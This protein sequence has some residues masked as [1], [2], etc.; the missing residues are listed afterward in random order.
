MNKL[1]VPSHLIDKA[2]HGLVPFVGGIVEILNEFTN[3]HELPPKLKG[4]IERFEVREWAQVY[5][6][7]EML[8]GLH[9]T[10]FSIAN[11]LSPTEIVL[12]DRVSSD[13]ALQAWN[14]RAWLAF[15]QSW[16]AD[17]D[18]GIGIDALLDG[19]PLPLRAGPEG[20]ASGSVQGLLL[21]IAL[22]MCHNSFACM[23]H[24]QSLFQLV[25]AAKAGDDDALLKA[26]QIDK[27]CLT[28]IPYFQARL[29]RA[30]VAGD[31]RFVQRV[32]QYR[33]KPAFQS[34]TQLQP[35]F[36]VFSFLDT[37]GLLDDYALDLE[38]FADLCQ[39]LGVYGPADDAADLDSFA[40][41]LRR[42][43]AQYHTQRPHSK[44]PLRVKDTR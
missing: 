42:F 34:A 12:P 35:L 20:E 11:K 5:E 3:H 44:I 22:V 41:T 33:A 30:V 29:T 2:L 24:R 31:T 8:L 28:D 7:P 27:A 43:Q 21:V 26:I 23:V 1:P 40:R 14:E 4:L 38:R 6:H 15:E 9:L 39:S 36:L 10:L 19:P 13:E 37:A 18:G 25:A 32:T 16:G 17:G